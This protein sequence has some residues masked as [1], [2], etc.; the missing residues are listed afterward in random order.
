MRYNSPEF[1]QWQTS[2]ELWEWCKLGYMLGREYGEYMRQSRRGRAWSIDCPF[3]GDEP[4]VI[5]VTKG[6][7]GE[8]GAWGCPHVEDCSGYDWCHRV[9]P[10]LRGIVADLEA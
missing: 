7:D 2:V 1:R 5:I 8:V 3:C 6:A 10:V 9:V 4:L